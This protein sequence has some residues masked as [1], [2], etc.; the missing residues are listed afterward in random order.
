MTSRNKKLVPG[1]TINYAN[2]NHLT[3]PSSNRSHLKNMTSTSGLRP[4]ESAAPTSTQSLAAGVNQIYLFALAT[5]LLARRLRWAVKWRLLRLE[6]VL[7][8]VPKSGHAW[9]AK[10]ASQT[11][12]IIAPNRLVRRSLP[13]DITYRSSLTRYLQCSLSRRHSLSRWICQPHSRTRIF[14]FS[15]SG[16]Y[17]IGTGRPNG[18]HF[19][20]FDS[21][22]FLTIISSYV[23]ASLRGVL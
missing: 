6:I 5:K 12:R 7:G 21:T 2:A 10:C 3:S 16:Q 9:T 15:D 11:M 13:M 22:Y 14:Y 20:P 8:W 4:V 17:F 23:P 19:N 1:P 18:N